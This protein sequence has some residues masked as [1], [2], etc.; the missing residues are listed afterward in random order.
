MKIYRSISQ[1]SKAEI[2][3]AFGQAHR[4]LSHDGLTLLK[5]KGQKEFGRILIII[6]KKVGTAPERN[7]IKRQIKTIFYEHKLYEKAIDWIAI[8]RQ[9]IK[10]LSFE[11]LKKLL[12]EKIT[13]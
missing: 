3:N 5:S 7:K 10:K 4:V 8:V 13:S 1:F 6:P 2:D 9:P 12:L 11:Q